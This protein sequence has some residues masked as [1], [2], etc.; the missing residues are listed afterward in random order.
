MNDLLV[1]GV[2]GSLL[3]LLGAEDN[4]AAVL[5]YIH[6]NIQHWL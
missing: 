2:E 5:K 4:S 3:A 6:Y 1:V